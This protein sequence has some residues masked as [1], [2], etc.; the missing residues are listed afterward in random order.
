MKETQKPGQH[1]GPAKTCRYAAAP[2][3]VNETEIR[4]QLAAH[5]WPFY[6]YA[7][8]ADDGAIFYIGKGQRTRLLD[9]LATAADGQPGTKHEAIR[10]L[11]DRVRFAILLSCTDEDAAKA[12]EAF[13]ID[14]CWELGT[15]TNQRRETVA[16]VVASIEREEPESPAATLVDTLRIL[17]EASAAVDRAAARAGIAA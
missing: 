11:G 6:V 12:A 13:H 15:L 3:A 7:L 4:Q 5:R 14:A 16:S 8:C 9:H 10:A 1:S 2:W 17:E